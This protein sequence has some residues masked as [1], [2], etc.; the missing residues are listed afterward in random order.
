VTGATSRDKVVEIDADPVEAGR[1]RDALLGPAD[2][3]AVP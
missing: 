1:R 2:G 3:G